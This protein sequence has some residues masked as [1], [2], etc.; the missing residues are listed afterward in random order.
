M[1]LTTVVA[2]SCIAQIIVTTLL[3]F[4]EDEKDSSG[5]CMRIYSVIGARINR[6]PYSAVSKIALEI[7]GMFS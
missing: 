3:N 6:T 5:R 1:L 7:L 4:L 2:Q